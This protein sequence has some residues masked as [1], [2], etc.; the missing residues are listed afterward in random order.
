MTTDASPNGPAPPRTGQVPVATD[1]APTPTDPLAPLIATLIE[2]AEREAAEV[3]A[4]ADADAAA[5]VARDRA[6]A[7]SIRAEARAKGA[8]DAANVLSAERARAEREARALLLAAQQEAHESARRAARDAVCGLKDDPGYPAL[9]AA[10]RARAEAQLGPGARIVELPRG[11]IAAHAD[12][13]RLEFGLDA[14]ADDL[15]DDLGADIAELWA[16]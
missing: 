11:G 1:S 2:R 13:R 16:P 12:D 3:L 9:V 6:E 4:Q 10:L 5:T 8:T 15:I 7:E 14:L